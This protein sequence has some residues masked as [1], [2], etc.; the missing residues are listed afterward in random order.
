LGVVNYDKVCPVKK[1]LKALTEALAKN[2]DK[3]PSSPIL[4]E[5]LI[6]KVCDIVELTGTN[7]FL[8]CE[9]KHEGEGVVLGK[10]LIEKQGSNRYVVKE[11]NEKNEWFWSRSCQEIERKDQEI[12]RK[13]QEI[14]R[15]D[16]L[17]ANISQE[18]SDTSS[19]AK[20]NIGE[21]LKKASDAN[22]EVLE[23]NQAL[24]NA[25][26]DRV[27]REQ[28]LI[29][30]DKAELLRSQACN[31]YPEKT[32]FFSDCFQKYRASIVLINSSLVLEDN[33]ADFVDKTEMGRKASDL[34]DAI[35]TN[36]T[37]S[38]IDKSCHDSKI[39]SLNWQIDGDRQ[40]IQELKGA[41]M[42]NLT[43]HFDKMET[44]GTCKI[45]K[46]SEFNETL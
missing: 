9:I 38:L 34:Y 8:S 12:E 45:T 7:Q 16:Q 3:N 36:R 39:N 32:D 6:A 21:A 10:L 35:I 1:E 31:S 20:R 40:T 42:G 37:D 26:N 15:K 30:E 14:E 18:L 13:D 22:K 17:I 43:R 44:N 41:L 4:K 46:K 25:N 29:L 11:A 2:S 33:V 28:D 19:A 24:A 23:K 27:A 5:S